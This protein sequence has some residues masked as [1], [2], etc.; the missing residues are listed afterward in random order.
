[1]SL[2]VTT[3]Q[4]GAV[5]FWKIL[6]MFDGLELL[7]NE[8]DENDKISHL[9]VFFLRIWTSFILQISSWF[10]DCV[11]CLYYCLHR[12]CVK[13]IGNCCARLVRKQN[14]NKYSLF[15]L[16]F[17]YFC[18]AFVNWVFPNFPEDIRFNSIIFTIIISHL[19]FKELGSCRSTCHQ[20]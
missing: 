5:H 3:Y 19:G 2:T 13:L 6:E 17:F 7:T 1:M 10:F 16:L 18:T 11:L 15:F 14:N 9:S 20:N 12:G 4:L 8:Y